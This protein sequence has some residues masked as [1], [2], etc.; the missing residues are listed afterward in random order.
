MLEIIVLIV[1]GKSIARI[2]R[3][4]GRSPVGYV[5]TLI[6]FWFGFELAGGVVG[7]IVSLIVYPNEDPALIILLPIAWLG[8]AFG[9]GLAF[10]IAS[11]VSSLHD[12]Y[13]DDYDERSLRRRSNAP[14]DEAY[15]DRSEG[16]RDRDRDRYREE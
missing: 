2:V 13:D 5:V 12:R 1:L 15:W 9:A 11:S 7:V 8:A 16:D 4:K 14:S 6:G 3:A 10:L